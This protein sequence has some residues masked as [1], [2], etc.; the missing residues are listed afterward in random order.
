MDA[1]IEALK[2]AP[3]APRRKLVTAAEL[4]RMPRGTVRYDLI[5]GEVVTMSPTGT[6]HG[7]TAS[8]IDRRLGDYV[9]AHELGEVTGAETGFRVAYDP[10]TVRAPDC[11]FISRERI[12]P[13]GLPEGYFPGAPDVAVEVVSPDDRYSEVEK[14]VKMWFEAG[15]LRVWVLNPLQRTASDYSAP[16]RFRILREEDELE[17]GEVVPGFRCRVAELFPSA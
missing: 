10:D 6:L 15:A 1:T 13:D 3:Q 12:P 16:R 11:A 14:K 4:L 7:A 9:E 8:R 5:R 2:T 17:G